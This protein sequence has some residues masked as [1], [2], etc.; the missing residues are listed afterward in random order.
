MTVS[1]AKAM[2]AEAPLKAKGRAVAMIRSLVAVALLALVLAPLATL[3][4]LGGLEA[5]ASIR[6]VRQGAVRSVSFDALL[7]A[8]R[9]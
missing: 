7:A 9:L 4:Q 5:H 1:G 6:I 2:R 3:H 8:T